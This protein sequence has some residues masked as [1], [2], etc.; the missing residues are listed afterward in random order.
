MTF[1]LNQAAK[2]KALF[3]M[4][5]GLCV[6]TALQAQV[7]ADSLPERRG[8]VDSFPHDPKYYRTYSGFLAGRVFL[9]RRY[10]NLRMS[11]NDNQQPSFRYTPNSPINLGIGATYN[12]LT[13]NL[14]FAFKF[15]N[16]GREDQGETK[17]IDFQSFIYGRRAIL[18]LF[19]QFYK[20]FYIDPSQL[21][22]ATSPYIKADLRTGQL[23]FGYL[24]MTNW[25]RFSARAAMLQSERQLKSAGTWLIGLN[26]T[27]VAAKSDSTM[28]PEMP[29]FEKLPSL[30]R[31]KSFEI[32]PSFGYAYNYVFLKRFFAMG[33]LTGHLNLNY[34]KEYTNEGQNTRWTLGPNLSYKFAMGYSKPNWSAAITWTEYWPNFRTNNYSFLARNGIFRVS[35]VYRFVPGPKIQRAFKPIDDIYQKS[36]ER[37]KRLAA[38]LKPSSILK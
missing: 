32:G 5:L 16:P 18:D 11:D 10:N 8:P 20:G 34:A 35:W 27:Y 12:W 14:G 22:G 31:V 1:F 37:Y 7:S 36:Y 19:A 30:R 17:S 13:I 29:G 38:K 9:S 23:G 28:L 2:H 15:L 4:V 21:Q 24:Y 33:M 26:S 25:K 3:I 6:A